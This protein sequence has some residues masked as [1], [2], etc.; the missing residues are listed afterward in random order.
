MNLAYFLVLINVCMCR[1]G[2]GVCGAD[3]G[4]GFGTV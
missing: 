2:Y 3:K 1:T 4:A